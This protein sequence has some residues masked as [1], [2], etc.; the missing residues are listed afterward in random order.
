[1]TSFDT[2]AEDRHRR[3][4]YSRTNRPLDSEADRLGIAGEVALARLLGIPHEPSAAGP[5]PGYQLVFN[6]L[7]IKVL[8]SRTPGHL[9]VK[10]GKVAA[11]L[12]V[13]C[14]CTGEPDPANIWFAGW[15]PASVVRVA[16]VKT[17]NRSADYTVPSHAVPRDALRPITELTKALGLPD[18]ELPR[19]Q[20][21]LF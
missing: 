5:T 7:R 6:A 12:Y 8:T 20:S 4:K 2:L 19:Q 14:G 18:P 10:H 3:N 15:C 16:E 9:L 21:S 11:D 13:L 17:M 1:M